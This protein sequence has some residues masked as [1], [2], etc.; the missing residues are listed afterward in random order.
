MFN[1][2]GVPAVMSCLSFD[3]GEISGWFRQR[4]AEI[5]PGAPPLLLV[6]LKFPQPPTTSAYSPA[7]TSWCT[8]SIDLRMLMS[9][10][11]SKELLRTDEDG[12]TTQGV[13]PSRFAL[14]TYVKVY[15]TCRLRRVW[16]TAGKE[17]D[18]VRRPWELE[19]YG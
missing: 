17:S 12:Q 18:A 15:A 8:L 11:N 6:P 7:L 13:F 3:I 14:V 5:V 10:F 1:L 4:G 19:L 2:S 16:F 9:H